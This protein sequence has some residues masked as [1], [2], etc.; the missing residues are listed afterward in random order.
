MLLLESV[1]RTESRGSRV[2]AQR[3]VG[4]YQFQSQLSVMMVDII[5]V[6]TKVIT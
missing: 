3:Y 2:T 5:A 1:S 4:G 6:C